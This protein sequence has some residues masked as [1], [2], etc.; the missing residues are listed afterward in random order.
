MRYV[1]IAAAV[2]MMAT[3]ARGEAT[4]KPATAPATRSAVL[5]TPGFVAKTRE[6]VKK[7]R[8]KKADADG[9]IQRATAV[10]RKVA[11][12]F[13]NNPSLS[14]KLAESICA[15]RPAIGMTM[16]QLNL[17]AL[18]NMISEG[19][20]QMVVDVI[21]FS[22]YPTTWDRQGHYTVRL[23]DGKVEQVTPHNISMPP[24]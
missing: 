24:Q 9:L 6:A 2:L 21:P 23:S 15:A 1:T 17:F 14:P 7:Q 12:Y 18:V 5:P 3:M 13:A 16:D 19:R 4:T 8:L 10:D 11:K 22:P 20:T